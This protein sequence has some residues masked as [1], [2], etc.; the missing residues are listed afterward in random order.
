MREKQGDDI[1]CLSLAVA[2]EV[3]SVSTDVKCNESQS[4]QT[5]RNFN[6][7]LPFGTLRDHIIQNKSAT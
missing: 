2:A 7:L 6:E 3:M 1:S 4:T 5:M